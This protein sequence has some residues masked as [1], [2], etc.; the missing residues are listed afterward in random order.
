M[1]YVITAL[2]NKGAQVEEQL[3]AALPYSNRILTYEVT[4]EV[5]QRLFDA[6]AAR[7]G[8]DAFLQTAGVKLRVEAGHALDVAI[9][10]KPLDP[11]GTYRLATTDYLAQVAEPYR[12][13][14]AGLAPHHTQLDVRTQVRLALAKMGPG[15]ASGP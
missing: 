8:T 5:L 1:E 2:D 3:R 15:S 4:G 9:A 13:L 12:T 11:R 7:K 6:S 10:G 14:L